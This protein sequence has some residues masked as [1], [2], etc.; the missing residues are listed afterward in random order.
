[1]GFNS[2]NVPNTAGRFSV[3]TK[4]LAMKVTGKITMKLALLITS[5][6]GTSK[7]TKAMVHEKA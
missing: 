6:L 4:V 1:M 3:G 5:T 2:A 7:P